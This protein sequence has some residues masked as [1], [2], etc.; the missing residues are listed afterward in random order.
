VL[1]YG[2]R[3]SGLVFN[4]LSGYKKVKKVPENFPVSAIFGSTLDLN[5]IKIT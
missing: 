4:G 1:R 3:F 2:G 5:Q